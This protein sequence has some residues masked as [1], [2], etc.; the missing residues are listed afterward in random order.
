MPIKNYINPRSQVE[1]VLR[2]R[3]IVR[4]RGHRLGAALCCWVF[5]GFFLSS[6]TTT[7]PGKT[8]TYPSLQEDVSYYETLKKFSKKASIIKNFETRHIVSVALLS[9]SLIAK[10][11]QREQMIL[12]RTDSSLLITSK[13]SISFFISA[14][15]LEFEENFLE[16]N[17][18]WNISLQFQGQKYRPISTRLMSQKSYTKAYFDFSD[19]WS[20]DY[21]IS[22]EVDPKGLDSIDKNSKTDLILSN[23]DGEMAFSW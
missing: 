16:R 7:N 23:K 4:H 17:L 20:R 13:K 5:I 1:I 15:S 9:P 18:L 10:L 3:S 14:Y 8:N 2:S 12:G 22:F 19:S 21:L 11:E 6:C